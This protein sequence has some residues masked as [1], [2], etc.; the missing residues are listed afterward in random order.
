[1]RDRLNKTCNKK[2]RLSNGLLEE[3]FFKKLFAFFPFI[4][5][6]VSGEENDNNSSMAAHEILHLVSKSS[7]FFLQ[8]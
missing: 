8:G 1:M 2:V 7:F 6:D 4:P 3:C 5:R